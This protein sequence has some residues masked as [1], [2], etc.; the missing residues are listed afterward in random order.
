MCKKLTGGIRCELAPIRV[1]VDLDPTWLVD[2]LQFSFVTGG[3]S[4]VLQLGQDLERGKVVDDVD[5]LAETLVWPFPECDVRI[6]RS[7]EANLQPKQTNS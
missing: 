4:Q 6:E 5:F 2:G 1:H 3:P 7:V